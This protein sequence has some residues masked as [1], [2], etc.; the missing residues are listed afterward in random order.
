MSGS[1]DIAAAAS[2]SAMASTSIVCSASVDA[3]AEDDMGIAIPEGGKPSP[4]SETLRCPDLP[5]LRGHPATPLETE[6]G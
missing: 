1:R 4:R 2:I 5:H 6:R 3:V